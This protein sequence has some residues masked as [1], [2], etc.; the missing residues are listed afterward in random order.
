MT[1]AEVREVSVIEEDSWEWKDVGQ[2][3]E[4]MDTRSGLH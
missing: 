2:N 4:K 1:R 3:T